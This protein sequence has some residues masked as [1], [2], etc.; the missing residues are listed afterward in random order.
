MFDVL[1]DN[2]EYLYILASF[3]VAVLIWTESAL[4]TKNGGR[5]PES[6]F[7]A[8][9]SIITSS[10]LVVSG[11]ALYFLDFDGV[12]ISVPVVYGVYSVLGWIKG[13]KLMGD[14]LPDDPKNIVLPAKYL[15]YSQSFA[16]VFAIF[17]GLLLVQFYFKWTIL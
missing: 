9:I 2:Y 5:L 1:L 4:V 6:T 15:A 12:A 7:F 13:V 14:D 10:W 8:V 11:V 3:I 16:L 17:C